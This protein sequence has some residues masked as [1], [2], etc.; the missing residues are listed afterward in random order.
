MSDVAQFATPGAPTPV[1]N[2]QD[3]A[4]VAADALL[5]ASFFLSGASALAYQVGWQRALHAHPSNADHRAE[6][7][8][9]PG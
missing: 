4:M 9:L 8:N 6:G 5:L 7:R 2:H 1:R 3:R